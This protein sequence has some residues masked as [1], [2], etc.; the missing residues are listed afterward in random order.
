MSPNSVCSGSPTTGIL[1]IFKAL[2]MMPEKKKTSIGLTPKITKI[3]VHFL[4]FLCSINSCNSPKNKKA[5]PEETITN[6]LVQRDLLIGKYGSQQSPN[7]TQ[8]IPIIIKYIKFR[9]C[10]CIKILPAKIPE[11][12]VDKA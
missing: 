11:M 10:E 2:G 8:P 4:M 12:P 5:K 7:P 6:E 9:G 1:I 3:D